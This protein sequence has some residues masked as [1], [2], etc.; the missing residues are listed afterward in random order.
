M[1]QLTVEQEREVIRFYNQGMPESEIAYN[2]GVDK[3]DVIQIVMAFASEVY[4]HEKQFFKFNITA[5]TP[6]QKTY[7]RNILENEI[8]FAHGPAGTGK[9]YLAI[10]IATQMLRERKIRKIVLCRPLIGTGK[11]IGFLPGGID[12][13]MLPY[14]KPLIEELKKF[15]PY[16]VLKDFIER[17]IIEICPLA[18]MRGRTMDDCVVILDEAQNAGVKELRMFLTRIGENCKMIVVGDIRQTD[19][20]KFQRGGL[21]TCINSLNHIEGIA[22]STLNDD[23]V[24]RNRIIVEIEDV[25]APLCETDDP[26]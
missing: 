17:E 6:N 24:V 18:T 9:T 15:V 22:V 4:A 2:L 16:P 13:K 3:R 7:I 5:K 23:D 12:G 26:Y 1:P 11:D 20:T 19:L 10:G 21:S 25:L 14:L 8:T